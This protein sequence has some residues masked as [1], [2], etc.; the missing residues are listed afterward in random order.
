M[1]EYF[2]FNYFNKKKKIDYPV[3][4][5]AELMDKF[6]SS[7]GL[8]ETQKSKIK[9]FVNGKEILENDELIEIINPN[10]IIEAK[11]I[12]EKEE[13]GEEI[14]KNEKIKEESE[15]KEEKKEKTNFCCDSKGELLENLNNI[16]YEKFKENNQRIENI[17]IENFKNLKNELL[18]I[19]D[20]KIKNNLTETNK[21]ILDI[22]SKISQLN[23]DNTDYKLVKIKYFNKFFDCLD[24]MSR[25]L[26]P[27]KDTPNDSSQ[28]NN[29][30][31][32]LKDNNNKLRDIIKKLKKEI[33]EL[34]ENVENSKKENENLLSENKK[35][36]NEKKDFIDKIRKLEKELKTKSDI[37]KSSSNQISKKIEPKKN[38]KCKLNPQENNIVYQYENIKENNIIDFNLTIKNFGENELPK[39]C[40]I[41][42]MNEVKGLSLEKYKINKA[43]KDSESIQIKL[44]VDLNSINLNE[45][46]H[47]GIIL[48][49]NNNE[50]IEDSKC[51]INII[52]EKKEEALKSEILLEEKDYKELYEYIDNLLS[53]G[54][55]GENN[56]SFKNKVLSLLEKKKEKY[57][58]IKEKTE[59]LDSLKDDLTELFQ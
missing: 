15:I 11:N 32:K 37:I 52:I 57:N 25:P 54:T 56:A 30:I 38:Y 50:E 21:K 17:N 46:I 24:S 29:D 2:I 35:F 48:L 42:L 47:I 59:Y 6:I 34:R 40:E 3:V 12:N 33:N 13:E 41:Q 45:E 28:K 18:E 55:L 58:E 49:D 16:L 7:F 31:D 4:D 26:Y 10:D 53:I 9:F 27:E 19:I 5:Y 43:I 51:E 20:E 14:E 22:E 1:S 23:Q 44:K 36:A 39:N 8:D